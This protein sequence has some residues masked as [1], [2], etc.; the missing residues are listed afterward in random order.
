MREGI[1]ITCGDGKT[2]LCFPVLCEYIA[3]MEEQWLLTC[4]IRPTCPKCPKRYIE[5]SPLLPRGRHR[6][7]SA[8]TTGQRYNASDLRTDETANEIYASLDGL[9]DCERK[10]KVS[11]LAGKGYHPD[12]PFSLAYPFNG[13]LDSVGPDL[14]HGVSKCFKDYV[15]DK[16]LLPVMI[17]Y[18]QRKKFSED[19]LKAEIDARFAVMP[20]HQNLR[21][22]SNGILCQTHHWAVYEYKAMMKVI[23]GVLT[24][25]LPSVAFPL[26]IEYLHIHYVSHYSC[27]T[28]NSLEW[29]RSAISTFFIHLHNPDGPFMDQKLVPSQHYRPQKLHYFEHYVEAV[30]EKGALTSYNTQLTE[31]HHK[32][33][34]EAYRRSNKRPNDVTKFIL[35]DISVRSAFSKMI[36]EV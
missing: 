29:L 6:G 5:Q 2:R 32:P 18:W 12:P 36:D 31:L 9:M 4:L 19:A 7:S 26:L 35:N 22:F 30:R 10:E 25:L 34:K 8:S 17:S 20:T 27:H 21:R 23:V 3:D 24:G 15:L 1:R 13:I 16:W 11:E 14:L 28:E 33:L